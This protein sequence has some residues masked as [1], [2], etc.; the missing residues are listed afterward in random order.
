MEITVKLYGMLRRNRPASAPGAPHHPF[1]FSISENSTIAD[2]VR[3]LEMKDGVVNG[4]AVN[5]DAANMDSPLHEGDT[6]SLFPPAAG[7]D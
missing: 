7:G 6:I 3:L 1:Q 2:L 4:S 5:G